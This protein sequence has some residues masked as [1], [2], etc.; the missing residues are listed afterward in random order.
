[1]KKLL[2]SIF[3][4]LAYLSVNAQCNE[5]FIS[6]YVEGTGNDKAIEIYNP[7]NN[8]ISLNNKYRLTRFA[9]GTS[10]AAANND[11]INQIGLG[12]H[13]IP[14]HHT[15]VIVL[16][17]RDPNGTGQNV[18]VNTALQVKADT[19]LCPV[20]AQHKVMYFNGNDGLGLQ[21]TSDGGTT[22]ADVDIFAMAGDP[23]MTTNDGTGGW[24]SVFP[25]NCMYESAWSYNHTLIRKHTVEGGVTTNPTS[26]DI[27]QQWDSLPNETF[28][29][30]GI[31][32]CDC[33][34]AGIKEYSNSV[35]VDVFPNPVNT[36][37]FNVLTSEPIELVEVYNVMGQAMLTR[38]GNK[39]NKNMV[40]ETGSLAKG[41]Y[42][43]RIS[44]ANNKHGITKLIIQ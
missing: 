42:I 3:T 43:V 4:L 17:Q 14:P 6:Q 37:Y 25:Y 15:W 19:F 24:C 5:L 23:N 10:E 41:V 36:N 8:P 12:A 21:K 20:Y 40:I 1:M 38:V 26:F 44:C 13:T 32:R 39:T 28:D 34:V 7:T 35:S 27:S 2:L 31:H 9:N 30:L 29:S 16:D 18:P 22:W 11:P 33:I